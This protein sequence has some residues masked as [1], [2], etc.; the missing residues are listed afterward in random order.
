MEEHWLLLVITKPQG[1]LNQARFN[2]KWKKILLELKRSRHA[3][4]RGLHV[5][6]VWMLISKKVA[7][8]KLVSWATQVLKIFGEVI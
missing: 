2:M 1:L 4:F 5:S 8:K 7:E 3:K 6:F